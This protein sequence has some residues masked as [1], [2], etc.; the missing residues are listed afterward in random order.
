MQ[1]AQQSREGSVDEVAE[2]PPEAAALIGCEFDPPDLEELGRGVCPSRSTGSIDRSASTG[3]VAAS[4]RNRVAW[5]HDS[6][7]L[8]RLDSTTTVI[9]HMAFGGVVA[10]EVIHGSS[11]GTVVLLDEKDEG[12]VVVLVCEEWEPGMELAGPTIVPVHEANSGPE[13]EEEEEEGIF[14]MGALPL[15]LERI[16]AVKIDVTALSPGVQAFNAE[17]F[18]EA[19]IRLIREGVER[20]PL[21]PREG[22]EFGFRASLGDEASASS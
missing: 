10:I 21:Q 20:F 19:A 11:H 17:R 18:C 9:G 2:A 14:P 16:G 13:E 5:A 3:T 8:L 15:G 22:E 4:G 1:N 12:T 6:V 7:R